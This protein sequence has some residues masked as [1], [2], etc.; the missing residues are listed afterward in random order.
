MFL[1]ST[2]EYFWWA[3]VGKLVRK[4]CALQFYL[5]DGSWYFICWSCPI[6]GPYPVRT[7]GSLSMTNIYKIRSIWKLKKS[8]IILGNSFVKFRIVWRSI[9]WN[10]QKKGGKFTNWIAVPNSKSISVLDKSK[11][12][13]YSVF[14]YWAGLK[15][16][17][18]S[19]TSLDQ[20]LGNIR[21]FVPKFFPLLLKLS[22]PIFDVFG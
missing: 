11:S 22:L 5:F 16:S 7:S 1:W 6:F 8:S 18:T 19:L 4:V 17:L 14:Q 10:Q 3:S 2:F 9:Y 12:R 15:T 13:F 21:K 20:D